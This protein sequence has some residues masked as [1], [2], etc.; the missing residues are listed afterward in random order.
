[1]YAST[2]RQRRGGGR[3]GSPAP[4]SSFVE[5]RGGQRPLVR[6]TN[7]PRAVG[8]GLCIGAGDGNRTRALSLGITWFTG[9]ICHLTCGDCGSQLLRRAAPLTAIH[10]GFPLVLV[11]FWCGPPGV[12]LPSAPSSCG[13]WSRRRGSSLSTRPD[14]ILHIPLLRGDGSLHVVELK[15]A[16]VKDLVFR[17]HGHLMLGARSHRAVSQAQNY[18]GPWTRTGAPSSRITASTPAGPERRS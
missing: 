5:A 18:L 11:R 6:T 16:N 7:K 9:A 2:A 4:V 15:R 17:L 10:R 1:M 13:A 14:T 3:P 12:R 8:L